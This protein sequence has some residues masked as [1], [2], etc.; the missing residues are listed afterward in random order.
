[1]T[2]CVQLVR[3]PHRC[4]CGATI[5]AQSTDRIS[6]SRNNFFQNNRRPP[7]GRV[8]K[9]VLDVRLGGVGWVVVGWGGI[10]R[11]VGR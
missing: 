10:G 11:Y 9:N 4:Q 5:A 3:G 2:H 6:G 7:V 1:M 8:P